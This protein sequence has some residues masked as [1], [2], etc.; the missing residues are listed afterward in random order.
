MQ[1]QP[2]LPHGNVG[3]VLPILKF[4]RRKWKSGSECEI[5]LFLKYAGQTRYVHRLNVAKGPQLATSN[6]VQSH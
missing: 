2:L 5:S 4:L 6:K 1:F 3:P